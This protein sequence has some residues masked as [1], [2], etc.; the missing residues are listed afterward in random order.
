[1]NTVATHTE[2][3][4]LLRSIFLVMIF[5]FNFNIFTFWIHMHCKCQITMIYVLAVSIYHIYLPKMTN[6]LRIPMDPTKLDL[7]NVLEVWKDF[8]HQSL[9]KVL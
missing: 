8:S 6:E 5:F 9:T 3:I 1:M 2:E 7:T 4:M